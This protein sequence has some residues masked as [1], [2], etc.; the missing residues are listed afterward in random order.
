MDEE[1][2]GQLKL[3]F[4]TEGWK[5]FMS[6]M[7]GAREDIEKVLLD[8]PNWD[9]YL[10]HKGHLK[11]LDNIIRFEEKIKALEEYAEQQSE[12]DTDYDL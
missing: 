3:M 8:C 4:Q 12:E 2:Y 11:A 6:D 5:I 9:T 1:Y 10:K 7:K